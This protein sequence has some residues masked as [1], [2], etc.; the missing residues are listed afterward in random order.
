MISGNSLAFSRKIITSTR[1]YQCLRPDVSAP[2]VVKKASPKSFQTKSSK[3]KPRNVPEEC[4]RLPLCSCPHMFS[5]AVFHSF[6]P[7]ISTH[8]FKTSFTTIRKGKNSLKIKVFG[9]DIPGHQG[10]RR[11]D[12]PDKNFAQVAF[13]CCFRQGVA[14]CPG[15]LG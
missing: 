9:E 7:A 2:V 11:R 4:K 10:P 8:N 13:F 5:L 1:F 14:G 15:V 3:K 12:I 6:A